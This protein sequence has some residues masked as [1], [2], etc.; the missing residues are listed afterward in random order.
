[1]SSSP[2]PDTRRKYF[3][4]EDA[5][6]ALPLVRVIVQDIVEQY[7]KV[8]DL[9]QRLGAVTRTHERDRRRRQEQDV[10]AEEL[11]Q[12]GATLEAEET[13][14]RGFL[15]ELDRLGVELK[16]A[17]GLCDFP[18][19]MEGRDVY[20]CWRLGEAEVRY[21]HDIDAGFAGRKPIGADV[22]AGRD[23]N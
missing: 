6:K 4:V 23:R 21:W 9:K 12:T 13:T 20:L 11:A 17:D 15:D 7:Q 14:L 16:G 1:M 5:N 19:R 2:A 22:T 8:A 10:Y 18:A 3:T